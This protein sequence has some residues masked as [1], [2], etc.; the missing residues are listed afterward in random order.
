LTVVHLVRHG[1]VEN[2]DGVLYG[3]MPGFHLSAVGRQMADEASNL[4]AARPIAAVWASPLERACESAEPIARVHRMQVQ[5]Q[6]DL[7]EAWSN[8]EGTRVTMET[9]FRTPH[10]WPRLRNP[11]RPSWGEPFAAVA[12]RM[13]RVVAQARRE[14]PG[15]EVV[16]VSH[17][18]PIWMARRAAENRRLVHNPRARQCALASITSLEF[19]N[20]GL[21]RV[22]YVEVKADSRA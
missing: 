16:L 8:L 22:S 14:Y 11:L 10:A 17:Q 18:L 5:P 15:G 13:T 6:Q 1:E 9:I 21:V 3:R 7:I 20:P 12:A 2:P 4:L 19:D